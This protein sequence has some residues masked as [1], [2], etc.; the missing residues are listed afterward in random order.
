MRSWATATA[1]S[2]CRS[3]TSPTQSCAAACSC[4]AIVFC[5]KP[6]GC[7][8]LQAQHGR[9]HI[10]PLV[11][12]VARDGMSPTRPCVERCHMTDIAFTEHTVV[13]DS[14]PVTFLKGG[15]GRPV[16][17]LHSAAGARVSPA[18][19]TLAQGHT[20]YMPSTPGFDATPEHAGVRSMVDLADL[21]ATIARTVIGGPTD[22]VAES[23]GGWQALWLAV[24]HP[25]LVGQ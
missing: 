8:A 7:D 5:T 18:I 3:A 12:L 13:L 2:T 25:D 17:H 6:G 1:S 19:R 10:V 24:R 20:F 22:V 4:S 15:E 14:G 11:A 16:L 9:G 21:A 23:F